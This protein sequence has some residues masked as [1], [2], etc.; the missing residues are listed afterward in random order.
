MVAPPYDV[1]DPDLQQ[2][3][4]DASPH[5][6]IRLE[7]TKDE[8]GDGTKKKPD[9]DTLVR[10]RAARDQ[11]ALLDDLLGRFDEN[12]H[13][14]ASNRLAMGVV[15]LILTLAGAAAAEVTRLVVTARQDVLA[16]ANA[17][18]NKFIEEARAAAARVQ[19]QETQKAIAA[20]EQIITKAREAAVQDHARTGMDLLDVRQVGPFRGIPSARDRQTI[21]TTA[22]QRR[23]KSRSAR[24]SVR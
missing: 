16:Q 6:V 21:R 7:L 14:R 18:A 17:Q 10:M 19:E 24:G 12:G 22:W 15:V 8:P 2:K 3:L 20:A 4:Y 11:E 1:I 5:N 23:T 9:A 13:A